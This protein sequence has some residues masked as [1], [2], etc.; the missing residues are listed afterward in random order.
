MA[1]RLL[2]TLAAVGLTAAAAHAQGPQ[3][4]AAQD[5][6]GALVAEMTLAQKLD[7]LFL[8]SWPGHGLPDAWR[9]AIAAGEVSAVEWTLGENYLL[10]D[11]LDSLTAAARE[12]NGSPHPL[13][14]AAACE[15]GLRALLHPAMGGAPVPEAAALGAQGD[16]DAVRGAYARMGADFKRHGIHLA[17][18]P[19]LGYT[20]P[21]PDFATDARAFGSSHALVSSCVRAAVAGIREGGAIPTPVQF[22]ALDVLTKIEVLDLDAANDRVAIV[23]GAVEAGA[24]AMMV[25]NVRV[26]AWEVHTPAALSGRAVRETLQGQ[27]G[28]GGLVISPDMATPESNQDFG[29]AR[30]PVMALRAGCDMLLLHSADPEQMR[31]RKQIIANAVESGTL[32]MG[33]LDEAVRRVLLTKRRAGAATP[34]PR[35]REPG[36]LSDVPNGVVIVRDDT[37]MLPLRAVGARYL[38]VS[39]E[40]AWTTPDGTQVFNGATLGSAVRRLVPDAVDHRFSLTPSPAQRAQAI[41]EAGQAD[42]LIIALLLPKAYTA[43]RQ[44]VDELLTLGK[45]TVIVGL[46]EAT[47]LE[48][49]GK[50]P[51]LVAANGYSPPALDAVAKVLFGEEPAGGKLPAPIGRLFPAGHSGP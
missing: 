20:A 37:R 44:L 10:P 15:G 21:E 50:A 14:F 45:P 16:L 5:A 18:G 24:G 32:P 6:E 25:G 12:A 28:F 40:A 51:V 46:G 30:S 38:V 35:T 8:V 47:G 42:I 36:D 41:R 26:P 3:A 29:E 22:P 13:L 23:R 27:I 11:E 1:A 39:P 9:A 33:R 49:Y 4:G 48:P 7:Q 2:L 34:P 17:L 43:Q 31:K 19:A